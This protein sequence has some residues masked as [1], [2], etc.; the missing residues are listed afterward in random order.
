MKV[1][2]VSLILFAFPFSKSFCLN[3]ID[4]GNKIYVHFGKQE[5]SN[6]KNLGDIANIGFIVGEN[7]IAVIDTGSSVKIG[8]QMLKKIREIS[9]IPISHIIITHSHPDHFLGTEAFMKNKPVII[10]HEN[11]NRSLV[12]NFEFYKALQF[13]LTKD[14]SVKSTKL[15]LANKI[16]E[17]NKSIT[18]NLGERDIVIK[19]WSSGHTDNDLSVY[20][21]KSKIFWSENIFVNRIPS[22]RASIKGWREN[23]NEIL[24][25]DI[26][27]IIP[28]HGPAMSKK[29]AISPM[30]E[31]FDELINEVR[32]LHKKNKSLDYAL[33]NINQ[34]N[35]QKWLL[36]NEYHMTNITK[37]FTEL[38]WE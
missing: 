15:F 10:G 7:S 11:L 18:I 26:D 14:A 6:K 19:A 24:K 9:K 8:Q 29:E 3:F 22:I 34:K 16:V 27:K 23:L 37:T 38:E 5:D 32:N 25:L 28:G 2:L 17:K 35:K 20:D 30:L 33:K 21:K 4:V 31:Y 12:N 36:F 13:N 1:F